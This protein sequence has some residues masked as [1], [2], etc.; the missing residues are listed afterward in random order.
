MLNDD[1]DQAW[2]ADA[3]GIVESDCI[4]LSNEDAY[5]RL[6]NSYDTCHI[7]LSG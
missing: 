5:T 4:S 6:H 3:L 1:R 2:S 7:I